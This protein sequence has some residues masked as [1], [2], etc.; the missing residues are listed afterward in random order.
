M[1]CYAV[2]WCD[3]SHMI[4]RY[5]A[6][7]LVHGFLDFRGLAIS[8]SV[9]SVV[10]SSYLKR[11]WARARVFARLCA[12]VCVLLSSCVGRSSAVCKID[13]IFDGG[14]WWMRVGGCG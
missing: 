8:L 13:W 12:R 6:K 3:V 9:W 2:P 14:R 5:K 11:V 7:P 10:V 4:R 1:V